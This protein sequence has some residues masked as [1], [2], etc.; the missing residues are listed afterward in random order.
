MQMR[1]F[2]IQ[3]SMRLETGALFTSKIQIELFLLFKNAANAVTRKMN[4]T[5]FVHVR[6]Y[7]H[8]THRHA[9]IKPYPNSSQICCCVQKKFIKALGTEFPHHLKHSNCKINWF[10]SGSKS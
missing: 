8:N 2:F 10:E 5:M 6:V 7:L 9:Y 3:E 1:I 4:V